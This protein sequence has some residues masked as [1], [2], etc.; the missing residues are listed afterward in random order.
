LFSWIAQ[1]SYFGAYEA[2]KL[3]AVP[4]SG[5]YAPGTHNAARA[6]AERIVESGGCDGTDMKGRP[7]VLMT[8]VGATSAKRRKTPD[9][10]RER[11]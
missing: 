10:S 2:D 1:P 8:T 3:V 4:L 11:R 6:Q 7:V 5:E 9:P